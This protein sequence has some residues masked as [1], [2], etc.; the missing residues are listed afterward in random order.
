VA[1]KTKYSLEQLRQLDAASALAVYGE[2][3]AS[4]AAEGFDQLM[5]FS[6]YAAL[7][8]E[9]REWV[10]PCPMAQLIAERSHG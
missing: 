4:L 5:T 7:K 6:T 9:G 8:E 1:N 3:N 10:R 2:T